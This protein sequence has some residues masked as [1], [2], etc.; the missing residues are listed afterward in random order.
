VRQSTYRALELGALPAATFNNVFHT[1]VGISDLF[2]DLTRDRTRRIIAAAI[3]IH[4]VAVI[5][6][7]WAS[8]LGR[9]RATLLPGGRICAHR[10]ATSA[11]AAI[12]RRTSLSRC[13][14]SWSGDVLPQLLRGQGRVVFI[15]VRRSANW[16]RW[17]NTGDKR[18][19]R[20]WRALNDPYIDNHIV[21]EVLISCDE[22]VAS[23]ILETDA[24]AAGG[25]GVETVKVL[26]RGDDRLGAIV[27]KD[28]NPQGEAR[29]V[30]GRFGKEKLEGHML[31]LQW[32]YW[33]FAAQA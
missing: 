16:G 10:C 20:L 11:T 19:S 33:R 18:G 22:G 30:L 3:A 32:P 25:A 14:R 26:H 31:G 15:T 6:V 5:L 4:A 9:A 7:V 1:D 21:A 13:S 8:V 17:I 12:G 27:W 24:F 28:L 23:I 2:L 29:F